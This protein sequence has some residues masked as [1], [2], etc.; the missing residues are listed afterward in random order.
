MKNPFNIMESYFFKSKCSEQH[1]PERNTG[2]A[3]VVSIGILVL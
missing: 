2:G 3:P 1:L